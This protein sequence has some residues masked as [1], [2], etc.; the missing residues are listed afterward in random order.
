MKKSVKC[1]LAVFLIAVGLG[2]T[3]CASLL[4]AVGGAVTQGASMYDKTYSASVNGTTVAFTFVNESTD[5]RIKLTISVGGSTYSNG[6][7]WNL[8]NEDLEGERDVILYQNGAEF[9]RLTPNSLLP[10]SLTARYS[11]TVGGIS[12]PQGKEFRY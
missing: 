2:L 8:D 11:F 9:G 6:Y 5:G 10:T 3:S 7:S 4:D 12:I 1:L